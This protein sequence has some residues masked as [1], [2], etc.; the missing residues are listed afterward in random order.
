VHVIHCGLRLRREA[1]ESYTTGH[2]SGLEQSPR[3]M[4]SLQVIVED[5]LRVQGE[6]SLEHCQGKLSDERKSE[7]WA[8]IC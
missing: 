6:C 8:H 2:V 1:G 4:R 3:D 7:Q 5:F